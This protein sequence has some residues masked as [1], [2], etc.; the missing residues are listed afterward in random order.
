[1]AAAHAVRVVLLVPFRDQPAQNRAAHFRLFCDELPK[2]LTAALGQDTWAIMI[3]EQSWDG[4]GFSRGRVLNALALMARVR[5]PSARFVFHDVDLLPDV[6][7]IRRYMDPLPVGTYKDARSSAG[8]TSALT[9]VLAL[10]HSVKYPMGPE[11]H[12]SGFIGG[13]CAMDPRTFFAV[14]GFQRDFE[15][16]GGEDDA[17]RDAVKAAFLDVYGS[18]HGWRDCVSESAGAVVDLDA[19]GHALCGSEEA[20]WSSDV[21]IKMPKTRRVDIKRTAEATRYRA[22]GVNDT[23]FAVTAARALGTEF[24]LYTLDVFVK[25]PPGWHMKVS[26]RSF[27]PY[28]WRPRAGGHESAYTLPA[29]SEVL[30]GAAPPGARS[31]GAETCDPLHGGGGGGDVRGSSEADAAAVSTLADGA[32]TDSDSCRPCKSPRTGTAPVPKKA[33]AA[34]RAS[35]KSDASIAKA[36]PQPSK[37]LAAWLVRLPS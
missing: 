24:R 15:G 28:F 27:K 11:P 21:L 32:K 17:L 23:V 12:K 1:M 20:R 10:H 36:I 16:W 22:N 4:R 6:E 3:G 34:P 19:P 18:T 14:N 33:P 30:K 13:I 8:A 29:G 2:R 7:R 37:D 5:Y 31:F 25:L 35:R 26:E 9:G